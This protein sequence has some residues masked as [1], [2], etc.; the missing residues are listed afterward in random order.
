MREI[1]S[2]RAGMLL[3]ATPGL[4]DP[5]F[6]RTVVYLV[7]HSGEGTVGVVLNRPSE[8]AVQNVL[9]TWASHT[10]RPHAVFA[11]GPV[12]TSAAMCLGVCRTGTDPRAR[13]PAR[14]RRLSCGQGVPGGRGVNPSDDKGGRASARA[15]VVRPHGT[16]SIGSARER[17]WRGG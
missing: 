9:P 2:L 4:R 3:V 7:A 15:D 12:Q 5:N 1:D 11:G 13:R 14:R 6:R 8:T 17:P 16:G 10:A